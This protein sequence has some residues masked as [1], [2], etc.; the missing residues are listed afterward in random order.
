MV[1]HI[2]LIILDKNRLQQQHFTSGGKHLA[3]M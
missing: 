3:V 1:L 2:D